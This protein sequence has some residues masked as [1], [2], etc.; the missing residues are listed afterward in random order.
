MKCRQTLSLV[1]L[2]S[3]L[4]SSCMKRIPEVN[5]ADIPMLEEA[6]ESSPGDAGLMTQL[7]MA[8]YKSRDY[9]EAE[10]TLQEAVASGEATGAA[11]LYL[12]L[13]REDQENWGGAREAYAA[14]VDRGRYGPL[15][16]EIQRRLSL[17][18]REE[19]RAQA[20]DALA[21]ENELSGMDPTPGSVAVF[22][23]HLTSGGDELLPLQVALAD[24]M[25]TDLALSGGVSVLERTQVQSLLTEM[26]L[27]EAGFTEPATGARAGRMLRA[28]HVIQGALTTL[29]G[30]NLRF[31]TDVLNTARRTS[32]GEATAQEALA[33]LFEMEKDAV[34]QVLDILGVEITPAER[35]AINQNR[36]ANLLAFLEYG[37]GLM[38]LDEGNFSEA[39]AFFSQAV[40]M[41]PGFSAAAD[42]RTEAGDLGNAAGTSTENVEAQASPELSTPAVEA[43]TTDQGVGVTG[44]TTTGSSIL[45]A[46]TEGVVPN[47]AGGIVNQGTTTTGAENQGQNRDPTQEGSGTEGVTTPTTATITIT[48][49][50]PGGGN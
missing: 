16:E 33:Q 44:T 19:L 27:T 48:I 4:L 49:K 30:E 12:G 18:A 20:R 7:G 17:M 24:M 21:R 32:S 50:R 6:L 34:F 26:A 13:A 8:R 38:A 2:G 31:D 39:E 46:T 14:Y 3:L 29:P 42:A 43:N 9:A 41:D 25:T 10:A 28:E 47:P 1:L 45:Q 11:Y 15:K 5:P 36:A 22:P 23:F 37:R 40:Q 35:E